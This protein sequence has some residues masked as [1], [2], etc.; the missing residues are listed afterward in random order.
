MAIHTLLALPDNV[1]YNLFNQLSPTVATTGDNARDALNLAAT[2][3]DLNRF[4]RHSF[5]DVLDVSSRR[6]PP[7][8]LLTRAL[9][10]LPRVH[11]M[12][13]K[14]WPLG[15]V[16]EALV[17]SGGSDD[18]VQSR[19]LRL[20][21]LYL[22][23]AS[24]G[25]RDAN[26]TAKCVRRIVETYQNLV[27]LELLYFP[28]AEWD[29]AVA[30]ITD[31]LSDSLRTFAL[32]GRW[33]T[34]TGGLSDAGAAQVVRLR[35]LK[36]L[37]IGGFRALTDATF[38]ALRFFDGLEEL[39]LSCNPISDASVCSL[40][41]KLCKLRVLKLVRC[42]HITSA[43]FSALPSSLVELVLTDSG[44]VSA[45]VP[46]S[47][48]KRVPKLTLFDGSAGAGIDNLSFLATVA[49]R[50]EVLRIYQASACDANVAHWVSQMPNLVELDL[51]DTCVSDETARAISSLPKIRV[52]RLEY[53]RISNVGLRALLDGVAFQTLRV[54]ELDGCLDVDP[55]DV[56]RYSLRRT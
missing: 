3:R 28:A 25:Y 2:C 11:T 53:T 29:A 26:F 46:R 15:R 9:Q 55:K 6:R 39:D 22:F 14:S 30:A 54:F 48:L 1:L 33:G 18:A 37:K 42:N 50:L 32:S 19:A 51:G 10:R 43:V 52:L 34:R 23:Y 12:S 56:A 7:P 17:G 41:E 40:L 38:R 21:S 36:S 49:A 5:V 47:A 4:Y 45:G 44:A 13:L 35:R 24:K 8:D 20:K 16:A 27:R 31:N